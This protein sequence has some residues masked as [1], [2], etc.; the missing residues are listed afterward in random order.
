MSELSIGSRVRVK[1]YD[2]IPESFKTRGLGRMCG[3][4]GTIEDIL[5]S[6]ADG[7]NLYAIQFD[8]FTTSTKL[9]RAEQL[10]LVD[11]SVTYTCEI[12]ILDNLVVARLYEVTG[13]TKT[14]IEKGHGHIFHDG[15]VGVAQ[16]ASYAMKR[17]YH[18]L[19]GM[20]D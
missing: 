4:I 19:A 16:A 17:L 9:W 20:E 15:A 3:E 5:Y 12:E 18:K 11:E 2:D 7:C 14:E 13:D 1:N 8:N 6:K 10:E